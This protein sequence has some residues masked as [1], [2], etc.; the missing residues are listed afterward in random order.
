MNNNFIKGGM[1]FITTVFILILANTI[2]MN[3]DDKNLLSYQIEVE[4]INLHH[5]DLNLKLN[6]VY[7]SN[8]VNYDN[9]NDSIKMLRLQIKKLSMQYPKNENLQEIKKLV[10]MQNDSI[11]L[12]KR[13]NSIVNNSFNY[14]K[15]LPTK[16]IDYDT[17][18]LKQVTSILVDLSY[19]IKFMNQTSL[20]KYKNNIQKLNHIDLDDIKL[21]KFK[22][23]MLPHLSKIYENAMILQKNIALYKS[24]KHSVISY[25]LKLEN[26]IIDKKLILKEKIIYSQIIIFFLLIVLISLIYKLLKKEKVYLNKQQE[27]QQLI[28]KNIVTSTTNLKGIITEVSDAYCKISGYTRAELIGSPHSI[29]RHKDMKAHFFK[30]MWETIES[31]KSWRGNVKNLK[32]DGNNYWIDI[33]VEPIYNSNN[34][35]ESYLGIS[36]DITDKVKLNNLTL[37]QEEIIKGAVSNIEEQKNKLKN[38]LKTKSEFLANMSHEIRT[39][40]NAIIGFINIL[41][42]ENENEKSQEYLNIIDSSSK[43]LVQIIED[44]LDFSKIE[45]GKLDIEKIDFETIKEFE[46]VTYLFKAKASEKNISL[47]LNLDENLPKIVNSDPL[48]IKQVISNLLSNAIK[49]TK[50]TKRIE[51]YIKY[52]S[53]FLHVNV[54]DQG[55]GISD[56]KLEHIFESFSQ[57]DSSTTRE[58]GGTGLGLSISSELVKLLGGEL[59]VKSQ[60]GVGSE[61]YFSIPVAIGKNIIQIDSNKTDSSFENKIALL[62]EDNKAN[63]MFM[64]VVLNKLN[65]NFDIANDGLEAIEAFKSKKY[66]VILMDENMPNMNGIEATKYIREIEQT[67]NLLH[68]PIIALTANALKGDREK[69][70]SKGMDEYMTKPVDKNILANLLSLF[71]K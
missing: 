25:Y 59:K 57:E 65:L 70:L 71:L 27:L 45:S 20:S 36:I 37:S 29:I 50:E 16:I 60:L 3:K 24:L 30:E 47:S 38:A 6:N 5:K 53:G 51:V 68:T 10:S 55:K 26:E 58:F 69:F 14:I 54:V 48:R 31:G 15:F 22:E 12:I 32:K 21:I 39:P 49:F 62:V 4:K 1:V 42:E 52:A 64:K 2:Y 44:I 23:E 34:E 35:I 41:K 9:L 40:L 67:K 13:S 17:K 61:F 33:I 63:Q 66:D 56:D 8:Y 7:R 19:E 28:N 46:I 11:D 18:E 43:S